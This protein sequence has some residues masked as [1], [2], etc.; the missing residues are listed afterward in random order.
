MGEKEIWINTKLI[1]SFINKTPLK[2]IFRLIVLFISRYFFSPR[3]NFFEISI[4][5]ISLYSRNSTQYSVCM[6]SSMRMRL[7]DGI[8]TNS[9]WNNFGSGI[10][11]PNNLAHENSLISW[12]IVVRTNV[13]LG[14]KNLI[15]KIA[16]QQRNNARSTYARRGRKLQ[17]KG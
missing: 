2:N 17:T 10:Q 11:K 14:L 5:L 6:Y 8:N 1:Y 4:L 15:K 7:L 16:E 9:N 3:F 12:T 13:K